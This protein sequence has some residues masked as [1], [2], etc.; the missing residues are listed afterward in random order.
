ME[1]LSG[2]LI[3]GILRGYGCVTMRDI[4]AA[5]GRAIIVSAASLSL[6]T[7]DFAYAQSAGGRGPMVLPSANVTGT[8]PQS[9]PQAIPPA[10][11][12]FLP[13]RLAQATPAK[14]WSGEDGQSGD[15]RM[16]A[17][18]IREAAANFPRCVAGF[19]PEAA[20]RGISEASF[21]R[22]TADLTPDLRIMDLVDS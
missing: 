17:S 20:R 1:T 11:P 2:P 15:P 3:S 9:A 8:I 14:E 5:T 7:G 4:K 12:N 19:W 13:K 10:R 21:Q 22:F 16:T 6:L 18:A